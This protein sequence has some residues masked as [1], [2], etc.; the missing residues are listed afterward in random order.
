MKAQKQI[1]KSLR[2]NAQIA[3]LVEQRIRNAVV[4]G[5][6]PVLG[7]QLNSFTTKVHP[8]AAVKPSLF[9]KI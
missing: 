7:N 3:Q 1:S 5:S 8:V 4:A 2:Y 6:T 9:D